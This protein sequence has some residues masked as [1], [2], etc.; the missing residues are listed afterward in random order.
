MCRMSSGIR[1]P[2]ITPAS[3]HVYVRRH[4]HRGAVCL[5]ISAMDE[6]DGTIN[7]RLAMGT[8]DAM[9]CDS[10]PPPAAKESNS[11]QQSEAE[12]AP[13]PAVTSASFQSSPIN[14]AD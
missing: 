9:F 13:R 11:Q 10:P 2:T 1:V 4:V 12:V 8:I 3:P 7:T 14:R 5:R 6:E